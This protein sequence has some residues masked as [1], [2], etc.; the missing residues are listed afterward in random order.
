MPPSRPS[1]AEPGHAPPGLH[2]LIGIEGDVE[3][4]GFVQ[5]VVELGDSRPNRRFGREQ[6]QL[7]HVT[8]H[9]SQSDVGRFRQAESF[10]VPAHP[11]S[12]TAVQA[13]RAAS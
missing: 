3:E 8:F 5:G 12:R 1:E 13:E 6:P 10:D 11:P 7:A 4:A 9:D 2:R